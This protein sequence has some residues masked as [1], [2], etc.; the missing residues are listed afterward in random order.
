MK[1]LRPIRKVYLAGGMRSNWQ[2]A[3]KRALPGCI[4]LD[5]RDHHFKAE[6]DYTAWDLAAVDACDIVLGF[7]EKSN[8]SAAG[9]ALEFGYAAAQG[10]TMLYVEELEFPFTRYFGM[11][12]AVADLAVND[13]PTALRHLA[14]LLDLKA[15]LAAWDAFRETT[16]CTA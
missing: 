3:V 10:K 15:D 13:M 6:A 14:Q 4:Y 8:P 1:Q 7:V 9:L 12:R 11:V 5:P 2:D 16:G